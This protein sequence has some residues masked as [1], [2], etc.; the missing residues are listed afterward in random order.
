MRGLRS[1]PHS[2]I[3]RWSPSYHVPTLPD[4][5]PEVTPEEKEAVCDLLERRGLWGTDLPVMLGLVEV[6]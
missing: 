2:V 6:E 5:L 4:D 1:E 3:R